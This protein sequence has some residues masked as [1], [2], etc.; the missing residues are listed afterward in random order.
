MSV[1]AIFRQLTRVVVSNVGVSR[2][3]RLMFRAG[4][5]LALS[6][7]VLISR[8]HFSRSSLQ[9]F[10]AN[11][12]MLFYLFKGKFRPDRDTFPVDAWGEGMVQ[13]ER[14]GTE[15]EVTNYGSRY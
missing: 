2:A 15:W 10:A 1:I 14:I 7:V 8:P 11:T 13:V 4:V 9:L 3:S 6:A 5:V 12:V